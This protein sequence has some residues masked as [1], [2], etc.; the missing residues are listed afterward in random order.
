[1]KLQIVVLTFF[2]F[3]ASGRNCALS[4]AVGNVFTLFKNGLNLPGP[5][6]SFNKSLTTGIFEFKFKT[7]VETALVLYQ[8]SQ[9]HSDFIELYLREGRI[10]FTFYERNSYVSQKVY[11]DFEWH[12]VRIERNRSG[13]SL[14]LDNKIVKTFNTKGLNSIFTSNVQIGGFPPSRSS[15]RNSV[16]SQAA[17]KLYILPYHK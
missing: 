3:L 8:D 10:H 1:M 6:M 14:A 4:S 15:N 16:S 12:F 17:L 11:N 2:A 9:G 13:T 5:S 7:F